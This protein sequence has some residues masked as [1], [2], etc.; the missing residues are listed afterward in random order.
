MKAVLDSPVVKDPLLVEEVDS[1]RIDE[2]KL[3]TGGFLC[4]TGY[5]IFASDLFEAHHTQPD[6]AIFPDHYSLLQ[7]FLGDEPQVQIMGNPGTVEALMVMAISISDHKGITAAAASAS[8]A[9][10]KSQYM[11]YHHLL[12]LVSAFHPN[13]RVRNAATVLAGKVLQ[14]DPDHYDRLTILEDLLENCMFASLQAQAVTWLKDELFVAYKASSSEGTASA[15]SPFATSDAVEK[16]QYALFPALGYLQDES[17][18]IDDLKEYWLQNKEFHLK[19]AGFAMFLFGGEVGNEGQ[20]GQSGHPGQ[21]PDGMK[22]AVEERY[23]DPMLAC[24]KRLEGAMEGDAEGI[25]ELV[26]MKETLGKV[27]WH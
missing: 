18:T 24:V 2:V 14:A 21:T 16:V 19:V 3:S 27:P 23:V 22:A 1:D 25:F 7:R 15:S 8:D 11:S 20:K 17:T 10:G 5:W 9:D 4:L 6:I 26:L 13:I 12:T